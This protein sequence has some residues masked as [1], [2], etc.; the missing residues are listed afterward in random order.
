MIG[1]TPARLH[2]RRIVTKSI[3]LHKGLFRS[4]LS[5]VANTM[6]R[7]RHVLA[8][9]ANSDL[10]QFAKDLSVRGPDLVQMICRQRKMYWHNHYEL[11]NG[12][13]QCAVTWRGIQSRRR[14]RPSID[15]LV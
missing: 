10:I 4:E 14:R 13:S 1:F 5:A 15:C 2:C 8:R 9:K 3:V 11:S 7:S 12:R 6:R